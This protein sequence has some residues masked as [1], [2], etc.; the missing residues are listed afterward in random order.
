MK[1]NI[2]VTIHPFPVP[3]CVQHDKKAA[4]GDPDAQTY[5][6]LTSIDANTL[7][8]LCDQFR[9]DVFKQ[10]RKQDPRLKA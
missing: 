8:A 9:I 3:V 10:A 1:A 7:S 4:G 6:D 5:F 2:E